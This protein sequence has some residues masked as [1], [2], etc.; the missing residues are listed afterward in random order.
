KKAALPSLR[1]LGGY[2]YRGTGIGPHGSV[3]GA[4]KDGFNNST[5]NFL[6]GVGVMWN[7]TNLHTNRLKGAALFREAASTQLLHTQYEQAMQAD[8]SASQMKISQQ[9]RQLTK[10]ELAVKQAQD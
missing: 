3:S 6:I 1:L 10:T 5:R 2:A 8:L 9:Y 4:W 7:I